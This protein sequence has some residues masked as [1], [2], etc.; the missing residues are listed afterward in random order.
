MTTVLPEEVRAVQARADLLHSAAEVDAAYDRLAA[1]ITERLHDANPVVLVVL[2]GGVVPAGQLLPR[3][4][5]PLQMGYLHATRYRGDTRGGTLHWV[6]KPRPEVAGRTVL[7]L[8]DIFD[9]GYTLEAIVRELRAMGAREVLSAVLVDK[10]H[11]R[12]VPG[13][14]VDFVGLQVPDRYVFGC[15]M[16]Y[17]EYLRNLPGVYAVGAGD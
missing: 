8:D 10:V 9:E 13:F 14:S 1:A 6:V 11:A 12:K 3:L 15:G 4:A 7:V 16:D 2:N 17:H 5:F